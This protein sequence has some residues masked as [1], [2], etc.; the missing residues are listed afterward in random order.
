[1]AKSIDRLCRLD[2]FQLFPYKDKSICR[3][4]AIRDLSIDIGGGSHTG[5]HELAVLYE[6]ARGWHNDSQ[7]GYILDLGT[8]YGVSAAVMASGLIKSKSPMAPVFTM[9]KYRYYNYTHEHGG[10]AAYQL[11]NRFRLVRKLFAELNLIE[12][13]CQIVCNDEISLPF[14]KEPI[15]LA[16]IDAAH[17]YKAVSRQIDLVNR[18]LVSGGWMVF[19]DY[20]DEYWSGVIPAVNEYID[21]E[22]PESIRVFKINTSVIIQKR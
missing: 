8:H 3:A 14:F 20:V 11:N 17:D 16:Y 9:D 7:D 13:I 21:S 1:M 19:H 22:S 6:I 5:K 4:D 12:V 15:F 2:S 18:N 10:S